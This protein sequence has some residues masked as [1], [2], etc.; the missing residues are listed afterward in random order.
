LIT[1]FRVSSLAGGL[2]VT[3][4]LRVTAAFTRAVFTTGFWPV[5]VAFFVL[6]FS[7]TTVFLAIVRL[8]VAIRI[9]YLSK[10]NCLYLQQINSWSEP[11]DLPRLGPPPRGKTRYCHA[12]RGLKII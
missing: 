2:G 3:A 12:I 1:I 9:R 8:P 10:L 7:T 6:V 4:G 11:I 5:V